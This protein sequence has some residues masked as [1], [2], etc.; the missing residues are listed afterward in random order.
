[1]SPD[2]AVGA[3]TTGVVLMAYGSPSAEGEIL[4]YYTDIR[5]GRPTEVH[6]R[7]PLDNL[8]DFYDRNKA[9][10]ISKLNALTI[11][12]GEQQTQN[13][14]QNIGPLFADPLA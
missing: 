10:P 6:H 11:L 7:A 1:M 8:R 2:G 9:A 3:G 4:P 5:P 13:Y 14:Y 12:S